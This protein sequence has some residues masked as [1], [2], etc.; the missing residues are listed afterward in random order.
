MNQ[1]F[2]IK[3]INSEQK[4]QIVLAF[5]NEIL[6]PEGNPVRPFSF[7]LECYQK[8]P[9]LLLYVEDNGCICGC[10]FGRIDNNHITVGM[11]AVDPQY[12]RCGIGSA[13][14]KEIEERSRRM[15][16]NALVLGARQEA[17][18]FYL[19]CSFIPQLFIQAKVP[20]TLEQ[21]RSLNEK[22]PEAGSS[23]SEGWVRLML[24]TPTIDHELQ[25][26][27]DEQFPGCSTQTVF[28]KKI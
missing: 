13:L 20:T 18:Q 28:I 19:S 22:Y 15:N 3:T 8:E 9:E 25:L 7:W 23:E 1:N 14:M 10:V 12:R 17:E 2:V 11:V 16:Y 5:A 4:L 27:Y 21:L 6:Y 26:K 24:K